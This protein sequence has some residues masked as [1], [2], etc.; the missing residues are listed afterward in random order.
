MKRQVKR[1]LSV[2]MVALLAFVTMGAVAV[3]PVPMEEAEKDGLVEFR[4]TWI[5]CDYF[6]ENVINVRHK[7]IL[8]KNASLLFY[9]FNAP[10]YTILLSHNQ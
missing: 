3:E 1:W 4:L 2:M 7:L 10:Y 6:C 8:L 5:F 9:F